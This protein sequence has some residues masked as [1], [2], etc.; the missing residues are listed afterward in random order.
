MR[1]KVTPFSLIS[2]LCFGVQ[3]TLL[4]PVLSFNFGG[5]LSPQKWISFLTITLSEKM[6]SQTTG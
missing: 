3:T 6:T 5:P 2:W 1:G 4:F